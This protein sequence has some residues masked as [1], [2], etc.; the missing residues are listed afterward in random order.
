[1]AYHD[2]QGGK[3][4]KE[5]RQSLNHYETTSEESSGE[6]NG[7][8]QESHGRKSSRS[9]SGTG[10]TEANQ[11]GSGGRSREGLLSRMRRAMFGDATMGQKAKAGWFSFL[12]SGG[13]SK[14]LIKLAAPKILAIL[15][16]GSGIGMFGILG[17]F[18]TYKNDGIIRND[19]PLQC[20]PGELELP[21]VGQGA[22]NDVQANV[23][24]MYDIFCNQ[25]G[26]NENFL[27][28]MLACMSVES[29]INPDRLES[30]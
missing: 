16:C 26:Y 2:E 21:G 1:M 17:I 19:P 24:I 3:D 6:S 22:D 20:E 30:D 27:V 18:N 23:D 4:S 10:T 29:T 15:V 8:E 14:A 9:R 13:F 11:S 12:G 7:Q 28:G 25:F 5:T